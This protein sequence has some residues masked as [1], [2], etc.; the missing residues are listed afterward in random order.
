MRIV[1]FTWLNGAGLPAGHDAETESGIFH[2]LGKPK[3]FEYLWEASIV[4]I[5]PNPANESFHFQITTA[6]AGRMKIE[7][8]NVLGQ[9]VATIFDGEF[10]K[11]GAHD[12][13]FSTRNLLTGSYYMV[14]TTPTLHKMKK[15]DVIR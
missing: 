15:V 3:P 10:D 4:E 9:K 14:M 11:I 12:L 6:E 8:M 13:D 1:D 7:L 5:Y 2:I